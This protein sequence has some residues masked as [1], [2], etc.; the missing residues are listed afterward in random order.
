[1]YVYTLVMEQEIEIKEEKKVRKLFWLE[2][3]QAKKVEREARMKKISESA[4]ARH[5]ISKWFA[6]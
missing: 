1:M 5:I 3:T 6:K 4:L 2:E